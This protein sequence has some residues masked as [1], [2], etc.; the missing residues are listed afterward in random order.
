MSLS[1]Y[2]DVRTS[3]YTSILLDTTCDNLKDKRHTVLYI[4]QVFFELFYCTVDPSP[5]HC[6]IIQITLNP[7]PK[8]GPIADE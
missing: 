5:L 6:R 1:H 7:T 2:N 8:G 4:T 3:Y